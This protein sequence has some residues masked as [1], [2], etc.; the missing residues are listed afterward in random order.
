MAANDPRIEFRPSRRTR[1]RLEL[2]RQEL[3][4][5]MKKRVSTSEVV[6]AIVEDFLDVLYQDEKK[7]GEMAN[8]P[9]R[10]QSGVLKKG[11]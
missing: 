2:F 11:R 6:R 3:S 1:E 5:E 10:S 4:A 9:L 7:D 8:T